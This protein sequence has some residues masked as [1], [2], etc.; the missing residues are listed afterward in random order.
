MA[1]YPSVL[2]FCNEVRRQLDRQP[3]S[4]LRKGISGDPKYC[5]VAATINHGA[6]KLIEID[7]ET[8]E[9]AG[10]VYNSSTTP[11]TEIAKTPPIIAAFIQEFDA[12]ALP[13][14]E[15]HGWAA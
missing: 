7:S 12:G 8:V 3:V 2:S 11:I 15:G 4:N 13:E 6:R 5:V 14:L 9:F 1:Q 10:P